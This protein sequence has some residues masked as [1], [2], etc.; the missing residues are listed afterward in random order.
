MRTRIKRSA[1]AVLLFASLLATVLTVSGTAHAAAPAAASSGLVP[2]HIECQYT[3]WYVI[4]SS[5]GQNSDGFDIIVVREQA[6][7]D[8][9]DFGYCG[10]VRGYIHWQETSST[11]RTMYV[12]TFAQIGGIWT[13]EGGV[14]HAAGCGTTGHWTSNGYA[15][16]PGQW[17]YGDGDD[18]VIGAQSSQDQCP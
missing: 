17:L 11:C 16:S 10:E 12:A 7:E 3:A 14:S 8:T 9:T 1:L 13:P 15:A 4:S 2:L 5:D 18:G 6:L